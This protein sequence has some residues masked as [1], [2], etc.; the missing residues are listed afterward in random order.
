MRSFPA[1]FL[2]G[3][4]TS[5]HQVEGGAPRAIEPSDWTDWTRAPGRVADGSTADDACGWWSGR[6]EEDLSLAHRI[7]H[8]AHRLG[9]SWA[10]IEPEP[11]Q[12]DEAALAR[13]ERI[14]G[15]ARSVGLETM[16]TLH[17][18]S[19]PRWFAARGGF[20]K[21]PSIERFAR[22]V[23]VAVERL[24][25]VVSRWATF[26]EPNVYAMMG[27]GGRRWPP[28]RGSMLLQQRVA[29]NLLRAH[30]AAVRVARAV[31]PSASIG[32]V[33]NLPRFEPASGGALDRAVARAQDF[34]FNGVMLEGLARGVLGPPISMTRVEVPDLAGSLDFVGLNFY[35][36]YEVRF[37]P[38]SPMQLFGRHVQA[39]SIKNEHIDWGEPSG[40]ALTA[41]LLRLH[42]ALAKPIY[43]TENGVFDPTDEVRRRFLVDQLGAVHAAI[44][45]GADVRGYFHWSLVD[46]FEWAEG[47][48]TPF[49]LIAI[50]RRTGARRPRESARLYESIIRSNALDAPRA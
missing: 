26:N 29:G 2:W 25:P 37:D 16:V 39:G 42:G 45:R 46:N 3:A 19:S 49:G 4:A 11:G 23:R 9:I 31:S 12:F 35:G 47:F 41:Q 43:V 34:A 40:P 8:N 32:I 14:L 50:D 13:Y 24:A 30:A 7:G 15:H 5:H 21:S 10:R 28:G 44:A 27:W 33:L 1:G 36:R 17:H 22:F 20:S 48:T 6:A 38:L 18:F